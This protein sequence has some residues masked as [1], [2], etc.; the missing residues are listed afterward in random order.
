[1]KFKI[2]IGLLTLILSINQAIALVVSDPGSYARMAQELA[3]AQKLGK[4]AISQMEE[5]QKMYQAT[6]GNLGRG[7][8]IERA[9][10]YVKNNLNNMTGSVFEITD[11]YGIDVDIQDLDLGNVEDVGK[12]LEELYKKDPVDKTLTKQRRTQYQQQSIRGALE[13]SEIM[14]A[15]QQTALEKFEE[16]AKKIDETKTLKD[17]VDLQNRLTHEALLIQQQQLLLLAQFIRAEQS[18]QYDGV[19]VNKMPKVEHGVSYN[20][21]FGEKKKQQMKKW[22]AER[23]ASGR[24]I[25]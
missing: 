11:G 18:I 25:K 9:I 15:N 10:R 3:E 19:E 16:L 23:K 21:V 20:D 1:M 14:L 22:E 4:T 12:M 13:A 24:G 7:S 2:L 6:T 17:A 5:L 8:G